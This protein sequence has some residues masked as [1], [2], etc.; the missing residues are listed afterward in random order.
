VR[1]TRVWCGMVIGKKS[2]VQFFVDG[3]VCESSI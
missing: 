2:A 3:L 1:C